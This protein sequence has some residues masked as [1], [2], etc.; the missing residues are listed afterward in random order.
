MR[1][2]VAKAIGALIGSD[3]SLQM[4]VIPGAYF[5]ADDTLPPGPRTIHR[6]LQRSL[7]W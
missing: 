7:A 1:L 3:D 2:K 5:F 6:V 4:P